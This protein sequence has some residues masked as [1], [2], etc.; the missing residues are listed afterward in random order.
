MDL[1]SLIRDIPNF[2]KPGVQFRDITTL[3]SHPHGLAA[4]LERLTEKCAVLQPDVVIGMESRGFMFGVPVAY[5]LG[6]GF[7]PVR[8]PGKLPAKT[9]SV[10][11]DLEY[12]TDRLEI[13]CDAFQPGARVLVVDDLIATGGTAQ[14]AAHLIDRAGG[15]LVGFAFVVELRDLGGRQKL[16]DVPIVSLLEY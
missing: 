10:E 6:A 13:H 8:K 3:L 7:V 15:Q 16:P 4:T 5:K 14:A 2:P 12:G 1:K 9:Y 11:Y